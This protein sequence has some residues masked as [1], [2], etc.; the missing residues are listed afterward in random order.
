MEWAG[1]CGLAARCSSLGKATSVPL[2]QGHRQGPYPITARHTDDEEAGI[3][4][5]SGAAA[6]SLGQHARVK[7]DGVTVLDRWLSVGLLFR[8]EV[9]VHTRMAQAAMPLC[10]GPLTA[11]SP[12]RREARASL[13]LGRRAVLSLPAP[14]TPAQ[15]QPSVG[16][17]EGS[18]E[19]SSGDLA[20]REHCGVSRA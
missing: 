13:P 2:Q 4:L 17:W 9:T 20:T 18:V 5:G 3:R 7:G 6:S 8:V 14:A 19:G 16:T 1:W 12:W 10:G 15:R 11:S